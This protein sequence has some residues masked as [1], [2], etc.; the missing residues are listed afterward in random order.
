MYSAFRCYYYMQFSRLYVKPLSLHK[1]T[2]SALCAEG[3]VAGIAECLQCFYFFLFYIILWHN[4]SKKR[5]RD[6]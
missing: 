5:E 4:K 2:L 1:F 3:V 6:K